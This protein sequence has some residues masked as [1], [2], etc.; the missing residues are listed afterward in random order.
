MAVP[1]YQDSGVYAATD[2]TSTLN[3][4]FPATVNS[5]DILLLRVLI[6][7]NATFSALLGWTLESQGTASNQVGVVLYSK[8]ANGSET[9]YVTV[10]ADLT[11]LMVGRID[12]Y[13]GCVATGAYIEGLDTNIGYSDNDVIVPDLVTTGAERL[14]VLIIALEDNV[15]PTSYPA[16]WNE[17]YNV[18]DTTGDDSSLVLCTQNAPNNDTLTGGVAEVPFS[19][20]YGCFVL[21]LIPASGEDALTAQN[22]LAGAVA[23]S[24]PTL[25]HIHITGCL[26]LF[27]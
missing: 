27:I 26:E 5:G 15:A 18:Q 1:I 6:A 10:E 25:G 16:G 11:F 9:G 4:Y 17:V 20:Y 14:A 8:R 2:A 12:R 19:D 13:S 23:I 22:I 7:R 21:A 24:Q 3:V